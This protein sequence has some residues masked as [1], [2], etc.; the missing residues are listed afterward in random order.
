MASYFVNIEGFEGR[1]IVAQTVGALGSF[2]LFQDGY[3]APAGPKR[4][5]YIL[6]R[7]DGRQVLANFKAAFLDPVPK[8]LV[9]GRPYLIARP[10]AWYEMAWA[11]APLVMVAFGGAI[12]GGLGALAAGVNA[13]IFRLNVI[14]PLKY[15]FSAGVSTAAFLVWLSIAVLIHR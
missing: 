7:N 3:P 14:E 11:F 1:Q 8:L 12:G 5:Q 9:D 2:K 6:T 13:L 10:L 4:G 15:L